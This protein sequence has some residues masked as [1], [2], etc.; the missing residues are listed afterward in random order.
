M[1]P[2]LAPALGLAAQVAD[3]DGQRIGPRVEVVAPDPVEDDLAGEDLAGVAQQELEE[4]ELDPGQGERAVSPAG[5][6]GSRVELQIGEA[7]DLTVVAG[8]R[9]RGGPAVGPA[10]RRGRRA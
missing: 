8:R 7:Q 10:A 2:G 3:V 5:L 4:V 6:A 1:Q 9:R